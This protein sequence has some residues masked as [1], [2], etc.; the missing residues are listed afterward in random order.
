MDS[1]PFFKVQNMDQLTG[2][3]LSFGLHARFARIPPPMNFS[4]LFPDGKGVKAEFKPMLLNGDA[5]IEVFWGTRNM[6]G[7]QDHE[8]TALDDLSQ[9]IVNL[10]ADGKSFRISYVPFSG[11][12][13]PC[14]VEWSRIE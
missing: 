2:I 1:F 14:V 4:F 6:S 9:M 7:I 8:P 12:I 5:D 11:A 13:G 10:V 3:I